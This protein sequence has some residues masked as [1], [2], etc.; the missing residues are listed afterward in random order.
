MLQ[1][2]DIEDFED[3]FALKFSKIVGLW[4]LQPIIA[5]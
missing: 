1:N 3:H 5:Q 4:G 2:A